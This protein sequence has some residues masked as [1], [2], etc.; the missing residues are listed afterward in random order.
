MLKVSLLILIGD[1][2]LRERI[3]QDLITRKKSMEISSDNISK[4]S[5]VSI[6]TVKR[7]FSGKKTSLESIEKIA[8]A[9]GYS[10][11]VAIKPNLTPKMM[12]ELQLQKKA[13]SIVKKILKTSA[14]EN[15]SPNNE[16]VQI[17]MANTLKAIKQIPKSEIWV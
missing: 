14:L 16:T 13:D 12:Y 9:L 1:T 7:T 15:Q 5:G 8:T 11:E 2:M 10:F 3:I 17:I 4:I 6:A